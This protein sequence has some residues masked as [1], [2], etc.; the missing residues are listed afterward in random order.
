MCVCASPFLSRICSEYRF[1]ESPGPAPLPFFPFLLAHTE[2]MHTFMNTHIHTEMH[3]EQKDPCTALLT[4]AP[5]HR[6]ARGWVNQVI[7]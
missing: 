2:C 4:G 1:P 7:G 5:M 6:V 3:A